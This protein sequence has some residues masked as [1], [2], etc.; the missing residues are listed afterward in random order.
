MT[1]WRYL[2]AAASLAAVAACNGSSD[3]KALVVQECE[4]SVQSHLNYDAHFPFFS[5]TARKDSAGVWHVSGHVT[6]QN[7]FG[8]T[9]TLYWT[10][11]VSASGEVSTTV[12]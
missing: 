12:E 11:Q 5:P 2:L 9:R 8:A 3:D 7:G 10:C 6:A 1:A 4:D